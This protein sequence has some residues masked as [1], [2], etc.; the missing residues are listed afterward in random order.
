MF[1]K[2][3]KEVKITKKNQKTVAPIVE[4]KKAEPAK[5]KIDF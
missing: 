5:I 4:E 1:G 3:K 2:K